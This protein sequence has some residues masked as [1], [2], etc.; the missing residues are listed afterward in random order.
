MKQINTS[1]QS[2]IRS[3][4]TTRAAIIVAAAAET[5]VMEIVVMD[6]TAV[7]IREQV[8]H[9]DEQIMI[10]A[11]VASRAEAITMALVRAQTHDHIQDSTVDTATAVVLDSSKLFHQS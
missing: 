8:D 1:I 2:C 7:A 4:S 5:V 10:T 9:T 6:K 11:T 3:K